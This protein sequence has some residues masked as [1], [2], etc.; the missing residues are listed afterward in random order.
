[1]SQFQDFIILSYFVICSFSYIPSRSPRCRGTSSG[2]SW[3]CPNKVKA[4]KSFLFIESSLELKLLHSYEP[5]IHLLYYNAGSQTWNISWKNVSYWASTCLQWY[6][7]ENYNNFLFITIWILLLHRPPPCNL[8][9]IMKMY[10]YSI[11]WE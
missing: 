7:I 11:I 1:M 8:L 4:R 2:F 9:F 10:V 3:D 5:V 6:Q